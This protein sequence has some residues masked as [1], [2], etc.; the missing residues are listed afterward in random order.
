MFFGRNKDKDKKKEE[1]VTPKEEKKSEKMVKKYKFKDLKVYS[2]DEWM[3]NSTKKYRTV[4]ERMETTYMRSEF[5]FYNKLFDEEAW[6]ATIVLKAF[7]LDGDKRTELCNL[8]SKRTIKI[9]ENIVYVYEG[10]GNATPGAYWFRGDYVWEA[11]ID[12]ELVGSKKFYVEDVGEV[13]AQ[14]NPYFTIESIKMYEGGGYE[15][16]NPNKKYL[17]AFNG[18]EARYIWVEFNLKPKTDKDWYCELFFNFYDD[19]G[20]PKGQDNRMKFIEKNSTDKTYTFHAGWGRETAGIWIDDKYT[21]EVVFM[22]TLLAVL[23]FKV[24]DAFE[25][26]VVEHITDLDEALTVTVKSGSNETKE[27]APEETIEDVLKKVDELIG[28]EDIK[29]NIREHISYLNFVKLRKEKGFEDSGKINLHSVFTGNPGTGKTTVVR[30]LGKIYQKM[31]LL[32]KGHVHEVDRS[33][34]V[35]QYIG[36]TAPKVKKAI[37]DARGGILF[38]DEA[39]SLTSRAKGADSNDFGPEV[40][41]IL[42]KEMSDGKGDIAIM[43]A[44]Y[45][46]EMTD[47]VESN[48]G[49]KSRFSHYFHFQDYLPEE[50][51]AICE[52]AAVKNS[53][54]LT[55]GAK[56]ILSEMMI[57]T[58]RN[59]DDSFG[60]ARFA[61]SVITE[62]KMNLGLRLMNHPEVATLSNEVLSTIEAEDIK[63]VFASKGK[64]K[65][66]LSINEKLLKEGLNEL[67]GLTGMTTIKQ[68]V[69][70]LVKLVRFYQETGRDVMNK[71]SLHS[72]F[73]GNPGTGKTTVAR[74]I[75]KIYKGLGIIERGHVVE[76][77]REALVAGYVGQTAIKTAEK[78]DAAMGGILFIDEAYSLA[79][80]TSHTDF[81]QE[82][83]QVILKR[84]EDNR[85]AFGVIVAGYPDN[86]HE[87]IESNPGFKSR[88][89]RTFKFED[90][91]PEEMYTIALVILGKEKIKPDEHAAAHLKKYF[92]VLHTGRDKHF[93]NARTV[94]Q[95]VEGAIKHQHLRLAGMPSGERTPEMLEQLTIEDVKKFEIKEERGAGGSLGFKYGSNKEG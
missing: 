34:L 81:G 74:I 56:N 17:K 94:R 23:P 65:L 33:D 8:E 38:I 29:K 53:V 14:D 37:D 59:R 12:G 39:Y 10:W 21:L 51:I 36:Q 71:F 35:A 90:Y 82:A 95:T 88:F 54:T 86:M 52:F 62:A 9:D 77:D 42:I 67:N 66:S 24:G 69:N 75:A 49:L 16:D 83:V 89:D 4:F 50:L 61:H 22:D 78:I 46:K 58:Y 31:G 43:C 25:E 5:T 1:N 84:M 40:I 60:N 3:A 28:M 93:G 76:V 73:T 7:S 32:S 80:K 70:D 85:G 44:G 64:K 68:E 57:E 92:E 72:V 45:P 15:C 2:S 19:A 48:P 41:E 91:S 26:G 30:L 20:Q 11:Y 6:D 63:K 13:T 18:K 87:F 79:N 47:F 55:D 27:A